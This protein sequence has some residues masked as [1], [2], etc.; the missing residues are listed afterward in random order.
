MAVVQEQIG[1]EQAEQAKARPA[2]QKKSL[3]VRGFVNSPYLFILVPLI[4]GG[5]Y[6]V[7]HP[8]L[9]RMG[10]SNPYAT[11]FVLAIPVAA[12]A[13]KLVIN[14]FSVIEQ[15]IRIQI[16]HARQ[17]KKGYFFEVVTAVFMF[18]SVCE[19]GPFFNA[20]QH[21]VL[22]GALGYITVL[23]FDLIAVVCID[24][25]RKELA[26]GGTKSG[27]YLAGVI[28]CAAVSMVAN[29]YSAL[30]NFQAPTAQ[31]FPDLLKHIA[32]YVGIMFPIMIVFLAF[33]RDTEIEIDDAEAYRKQQQKRV[34]FLVV[35][36][37]ILA[38]ITREMEQI[39]LLKQR[40]FFLKSLFFTKRKITH[41]V[42]MVTT[43]VI[44]Q[45]HTE[46]KTLKAEVQQK[47]QAITAQAQTITLQVQTI[48]QL[49]SEIK[50]L[51]ATCQTQYQNVA[52][53]LQ[54]SSEPTIDYT[55]VAQAIMPILA[56]QL[57]GLKATIMDEIMPKLA[58][59]PLDYQQLAQ[60]VKPILA[61]A[62]QTEPLDYQE[63]ARTLA[64]ILAPDY[65]ALAAHIAPILAPSTQVEPLNYQEIAQNL[66]PILAQEP[67]QALN[68]Q[69]V[70]NTIA[71]LLKPQIMEVRRFI[72]EEVKAAIPQLVVSAQ[73]SVP[74][75][76]AKNGT[77]TEANIGTEATDSEPDL[78]ERDAKLE[79][80][81][82]ELRAILGKRVSG[83]QLADK[84]KISR[85]YCTEWLQDTH[86]ENEA[87]ANIGT[88]A[89]GQ[90]QQETEPIPILAGTQAR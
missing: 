84:T 73:A 37:E 88:E 77:E 40:E 10:I 24:A 58:P 47:E 82:Q 65:Q 59:E 34:D 72:I 42:E 28:L 43:K 61:P 39:D 2:K 13:C 32:P 7:Q 66:A 1:D 60:H 19:A 70:A 15:W 21:D 51:A 23:A 17:S 41:V 5:I 31:N 46:I 56:P 86:P 27:I 79:T 57:N 81:Y 44:D 12:F 8:E 87:K 78:A 48:Q 3:S 11:A 29:L 49:S 67:T 68:Y 69:E 36:R 53:R 22:N 25:R 64:P 45:V 90:S 38:S 74:L 71:P 30:I 52:D 54:S 14:F 80:A 63:I 4:V 9:V 26:K 83:R 33:S 35:R 16:E 89:T 76:E 6:L 85:K 50:E 20:I 55:Q 62:T 18:V 75:I